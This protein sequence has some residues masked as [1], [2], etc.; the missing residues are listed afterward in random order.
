[1]PTEKPVPGQQPDETTNETTE[2]SSQGYTPP[3]VL[4]HHLTT[5]KP[6]RKTGAHGRKKHP[7]NPK[8]PGQYLTHHQMKGES[9]PY[10]QERD[11]KT[12]RILAKSG[13]D[14]AMLATAEGK[15]PLQWK[16]DHIVDLMRTMKFQRGKTYRELAKEWNDSEDYIKHLTALAARQHADEIENPHYVKGLVGSAMEEF[17][18][19][20]LKHPSDVHRRKQAIEAAKVF[21]S[22]SPGAAA[23]EVKEMTVRRDPLEGMTRDQLMELAKQ[24]VAKEQGLELPPAQDHVEVKVLPETVDTVETDE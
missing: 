11:P 1:M 22:I 2:P 24:L 9:P 7:E 16:L 19:D 4:D 10:P 13:S 15:T 8:A 6:R 20:A 3:P 18:L 17:I 14:I 23:P 12:G 5:G 21:V